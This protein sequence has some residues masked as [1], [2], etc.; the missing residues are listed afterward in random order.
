VRRK[1]ERKGE[2]GGKEK[3][4]RVKKGGDGGVVCVSTLN[5]LIHW[6]LAAFH[7]TLIN[8]AIPKGSS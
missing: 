5:V 3:R 1:G 2:K 8:F 4:K 7:L 6:S